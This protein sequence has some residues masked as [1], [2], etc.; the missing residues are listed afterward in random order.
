[1]LN[2]FFGVRHVLKPG[3][4]LGSNLDFSGSKG[5]LF[6]RALSRIKSKLSSWK[7]PLLSFAAR[8]ILVKHVMLAIPLI[9]F[10][11]FELP[12]IF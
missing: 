12:N 6:S 9:F 1:M 4:Y 8:V 7:A 10:L 3:I 2:V 11:F 5:S